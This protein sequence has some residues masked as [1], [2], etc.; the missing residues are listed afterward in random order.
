MA[1]VTGGPDPFS[2]RPTYDRCVEQALAEL[3][4]AADAW[5]QGHP[6]EPPTEEVLQRLLRIFERAR[7]LRHP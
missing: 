1:Q 2:A 4:R 6:E 3:R 7:F 5:A